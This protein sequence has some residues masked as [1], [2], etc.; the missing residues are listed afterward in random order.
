MRW[1]FLFLLF[2]VSAGEFQPR[3]RM[4]LAFDTEEACNE[5]GRRM[6]RENRYEDNSLRSFSICIPEDAFND[7]TLQ[8]DR[9]E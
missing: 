5:F 3:L 7:R 8:V 6:E 4:H 1:L 9:F 2:D